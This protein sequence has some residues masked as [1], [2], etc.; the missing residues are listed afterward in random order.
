MQFSK[1]ISWLGV[2]QKAPTVTIFA[3]ETVFFVYF[4]LLFNFFDMFCTHKRVGLE[5]NLE[6]IL[7]IFIFVINNPENFQNVNNNLF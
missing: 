6:N 2:A 7:K 4:L 1:V 5:I 3:E